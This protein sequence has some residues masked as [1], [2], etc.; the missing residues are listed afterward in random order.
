MFI[1]EV[2]QHSVLGWRLSEC[3]PEGR[4]SDSPWNSPTFY[5]CRRPRRTSRLSSQT[6][7]RNSYDIGVDTTR[8]RLRPGSQPPFPTWER[9]GL[10]TEAKTYLLLWTTCARS[11]RK[12]NSNFGSIGFKTKMIF[13]TAPLGN[14]CFQR[15]SRTISPAAKAYSDI[16]FGRSRSVSRLKSPEARAECATA[17]MA[18]P[19]VR[20]LRWS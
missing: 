7:N 15:I 16:Y 5:R 18:A 3:A 12:A 20:L 14:G 13:S 11:T 9:G 2:T 1:L 10:S 19:V 17:T 8:V 6:K 4:N